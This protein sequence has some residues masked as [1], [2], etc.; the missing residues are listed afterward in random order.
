MLY[1]VATSYTV[2]GERPIEQTLLYKL[3]EH[4]GGSTSP[5]LSQNKLIH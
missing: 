5:N 4:K 3:Q 2:K 1:S